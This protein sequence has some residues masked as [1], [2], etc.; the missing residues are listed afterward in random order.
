MVPRA[1]LP[2]ASWHQPIFRPSIWPLLP[3]EE[4]RG[5]CLL[6]GST[7]V[8]RHRPRHSG[9]VMGHGLCRVALARSVT[10]R[11]LLRSRVDQSPLP[12]PF[13]VLPALPGR[14]LLQTV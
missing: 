14:P 7:P 13:P 10:L 1:H 12:E 6:L 3:T 9:G 11:P 2:F 8:L 4:P 5:T